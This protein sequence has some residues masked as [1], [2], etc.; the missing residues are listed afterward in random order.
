[1]KER[2]SSASARRT[3]RKA[4]TA[5][6]SS[7]YQQ[8]LPIIRTVKNRTGEGLTLADLMLALKQQGS[9]S[10]AILYGKQAVNAFQEVR[11]NLKALDSHFSRAT[12][13][14]MRTPTAASPIS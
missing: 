12:S 13:S 10:L 7:Y 14:H 3:T 9:G 2:P 6:R 1:M 5:R 11:G 4:A 8:A